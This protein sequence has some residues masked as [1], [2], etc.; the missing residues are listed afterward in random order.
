VEKLTGFPALELIGTKVPYLFW[1]PDRQSEYLGEF[2]GDSFIDKRVIEK[3]F[4]TKQGEEFWVEM[5]LIQVK[6]N[7]KLKYIIS[8]WINL[9]EEKKLR[10][11]LE[12]YSR[13]M[14]EILEGTEA[15]ADQLTMTQLSISHSLAGIRFLEPVRRN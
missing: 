12:L 5:T 2:Q 3:T 13:R 11:E 1:P 8:T 15:V 6:T 10:R 9:T 4:V 7:C 14:M